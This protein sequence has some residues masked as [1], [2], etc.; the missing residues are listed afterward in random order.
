MAGASHTPEKLR[1]PGA[2]HRPSETPIAANSE[3]A[4]TLPATQ[5]ASVSV[6]TTLQKPAEG[7]NATTPGLA[8]VAQ[9]AAD[10]TT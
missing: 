7:G 3:S 10:T 4:M 2:Y 5:V 9:L 1:M 6:F 8:V